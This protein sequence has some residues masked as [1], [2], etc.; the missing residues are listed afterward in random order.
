M[1]ESYNSRNV[2]PRDKRLTFEPE[3]HT[4]TATAPDGSSVLCDSVTTV[5]ESLFE[6]FD[7]DYW[8][9]RKAP[10][11]GM[12]PDELKQLWDKKG[13]KARDLGTAM[14]ARIENHYLGNDDV[15]GPNDTEY[16]HFLEFEHR[17]TLRPYRT[18][19]PV[20]SEKYRIAGTIDFLECRDGVYN[21]WDWKRS[22]KLISPDGEIISTNPYGKCGCGPAAGVPDTS[23]HHYSLQLSL[24]TAILAMEY[25]LKV[26]SLHLGV[27]HPAYDRP[28][29]IPLPFMR[30]EVIAILKSRLS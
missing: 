16:A 6:Q 29:V 13:R 10:A 19:W 21:I 18:E 20:F 5:V 30:D 25:G 1:K 15:P 24:Y 8:A 23:Y 17:H 3:G 14:H 26:S 9:I 11:L 28:Y 4:Y 22:S 12:S 2:H 27:F 7:A